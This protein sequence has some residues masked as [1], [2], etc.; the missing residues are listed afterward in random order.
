MSSLRAKRI[1]YCIEIIRKWHGT[2]LRSK[3][4]NLCDDDYDYDDNDNDDRLGGYHLLCP[5]YDYFFVSFSISVNLVILVI[6]FSIPIFSFSIYVCFT[7]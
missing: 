5:F 7:I 6:S 2:Y 1:W 4:Y 3:I